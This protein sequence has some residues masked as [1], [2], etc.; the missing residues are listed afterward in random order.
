[1]NTDQIT[2]ALFLFMY[3]VLVIIMTVAGALFTLW[4]LA[5][6]WPILLLGA[7]IASI[8]IIRG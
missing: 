1:M 7:A 2:Q 5:W 8:Y 6:T 3:I 4:L